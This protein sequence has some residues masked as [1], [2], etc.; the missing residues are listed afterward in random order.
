MK[1]MTGAEIY[2]VCTEAGYFA[3]RDDRETLEQ[4]DF[5][6]A[7]RKVRQEDEAGE[8]YMTMFG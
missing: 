3:I 2:A 6:S 4:S 5:E 7:I 1:G 8:D